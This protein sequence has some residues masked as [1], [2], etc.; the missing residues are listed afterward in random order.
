VAFSPNIELHTPYLATEWQNAEIH[1]FA[2]MIHPED[3][4][5]VLSS[6]QMAMEVFMAMPKEKQKSIGLNIYGRML[7]AKNLFVW[8]LIQFP[9][10]YFN[11]ENRIESVLLMITDISHLGMVPSTMM[12]V[13]DNSN[14][15][16]QFFSISPESKKLIETQFPTISKR[17]KQVIRLMANGLT[18]KEIAENLNL[19]F[20]T[21][22]N[23]KRNLRAKTNTKS[24][25][26]LI[27]YLLIN[28]LF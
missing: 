4:F 24:A 17:E 12:T 18:S 5:Y 2:N 11:E 3:R 8:K 27:N 22:E 14:Q 25:A 1:L 23:H 10:L 7:N 19:A 26:E 13:I 15:Q 28:N 21:I 16:C 6:M 20:Y 9:G